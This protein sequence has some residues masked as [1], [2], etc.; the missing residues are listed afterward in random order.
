MKCAASRILNTARE[1]NGF[2]MKGNY[3]FDIIIK[4]LGSYSW[5]Q[6]YS[7]VFSGCH[8]PDTISTDL[9][10]SHRRT[11]WYYS[12]R[13]RGIYYHTSPGYEQLCW[14]YISIMTLLPAFK[15]N[16]RIIIKKKKKSV[17]LKTAVSL[18]ANMK[19]IDETVYTEFTPIKVFK[20]HGQ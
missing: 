17:F 13:Q 20:S 11:V 12:L 7:P 14:L 1:R 9:C 18:H 2:G 10:T 16:N 15:K 4:A 5:L 19:A 6:R 8:W 3:W